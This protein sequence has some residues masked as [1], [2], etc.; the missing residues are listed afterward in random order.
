M[1]PCHNTTRDLTYNLQIPFTCNHS[2]RLN[3]FIQRLSL[4]R[5]SPKLLPL[6]N[7]PQRHPHPIRRLLRNIIPKPLQPDPGI[8]QTKE[9]HETTN[10]QR[11]IQPRREDVVVPHPPRIVRSFDVAVEEESDEAPGHVVCG[12]GGGDGCCR[13]EDCGEVDLNLQ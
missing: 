3:S 13:G 8:Y 6:P 11:R 5:R 4:P 12:C 2:K 9:D 7:L 1:N 10:R